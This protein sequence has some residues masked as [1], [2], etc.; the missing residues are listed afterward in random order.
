MKQTSLHGL[1][2]MMGLREF[3]RDLKSHNIH[4][5]ED[6]KNAV[7]EG[8]TCEQLS[9]PNWAYEDMKDELKSMGILPST[10]CNNPYIV[11]V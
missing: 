5:I 9:I 7:I 4:T 1:L 8:K 2:V 6:L 11:Y 10:G 3:E